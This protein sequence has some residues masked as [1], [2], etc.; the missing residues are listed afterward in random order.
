MRAEC[1]PHAPL[2]LPHYTTANCIY[3]PRSNKLLHL[4]VHATQH[5]QTQIR[6][7]DEVGVVDGAVLVIHHRCIVVHDALEPE[8]EH[9]LA[10]LALSERDGEL[11]TH[12]LTIHA[13]DVAPDQD[14]A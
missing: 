14:H 6:V 5:V 8:V 1:A 13:I 4:H 11:V 9:A 7:V 10:S 3:V 12:C 2:A